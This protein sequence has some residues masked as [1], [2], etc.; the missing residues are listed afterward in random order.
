MKS[1]CDKCDKPATIH[2][3]EIAG[4]EKI[5]KH[6]CEDCASL[7]GI[8]IKATI[9]I[10]QL[11]EDFVLQS[12]HGPDVGKNLRCDVCG[13]TFEEFRSQGVMGCPNDYDAFE[14]ALTTLLAQAQEGATQHVGKAPQRTA[15]NLGRLNA[16][17]RLRAELKTAVAEEDYERAAKLRDQIKELEQP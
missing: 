6:L 12:S 10:S 3:T 7:E 8:T 15:E 5:E 14:P 16:A 4:G 2:L 11:L 13:I 1:K 17:L 9:P